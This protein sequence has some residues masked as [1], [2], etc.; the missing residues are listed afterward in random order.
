MKKKKKKSN[1][2]AQRSELTR[3]ILNI[4]LLAVVAGLLVLSIVLVRIKLLQNTHQLGMALAQSYAVEET[5]TRNTL[6][7]TALIA[8]QYIDEISSGGGTPEQIQHWMQSYFNKLTAIV[9]TALA[10][11][12]VVI[13]GQLI[14]ATPWEGDA[15]YDYGATQWYQLALQEHGMPVFSDVYTDAVTGQLV[16][17]LSMELA[18]PGDVLAMDIYIQNNERHNTLQTLPEG[19]SY[20]LCDDNGALLYAVSSWSTDGQSLQNVA[21]YLVRCIQ[22]GSLE[23]YDAFFRDPSNELRGAYY[24]V[25]DNG[26][27]VIVTIPIQSVLMG[28]ENIALYVMAGVALLLFTLLAALTV[29]DA[30]RWRRIKRADDTAHMLGDSF[31]AIFRINFRRGSYE[32]IKCAPD[33]VERLPPREDYPALLQLLCEHVKP[34]TRQT[35]AESFSLE[36]IRSRV[37]AKLADYGGDFQRQF[38]EVYHWVNVR[39]L[40]A[41][42]LVPDEVILCF[43]DVDAEKN[44]QLQHMQ[45]LQDALDIARHS[46]QAQS[47]FF[48]NMSHDMRTPLNAILGYCPL[49]RKSIADGNRDKAADELGKIEFAGRQ[50]LTLINDI[51]EFSRLEAGKVS[52][53][54]KEFDLAQLV[55]SIAD[56]F[57]VHAQEADKTLEVTLDLRDS[58]VVGDAN[59]L[60]QILNNLLS[61][62]FKYSDAGASVHLTVT[63]LDFQ[64]HSQY[65]FVIEDTGIG[66]SQDFLSH[67]FEPYSRE[68]SFTAHSTVGTGLGMTIVQGLVRQM[69]GDIQVES[70]LGQG[71]RFTITL[72]LQRSDQKAPPAPVI[73]PDEPFSWQGVRVLVAEDNAM[74]RELLTELLQ[75]SGAQVLQAINGADA[76]HTFLHEPPG[77]IDV[78]LMDMRMPVMDGCQA[79]RILRELLRDDARQVP[80]VAV[81]ANA[82]AEDMERTVQ[83]GMNDHV[84]KPID[85]AQLTQVVQRLLAGRSAPSG[86]KGNG[87]DE[88]S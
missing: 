87:S 84:A 74:N 10:D 30:M 11:P 86:G 38:G 37:D 18:Q 23:S 77:S 63:Q 71:T 54:R 31:Y 3:T 35:F 45:V 4:L 8:G 57:R 13:D 6:Q 12:Y 41:P 36:S 79:T 83:A 85:F 55:Q 28:D 47:Q 44:Q 50:L 5:L 39:T 68:T 40:Y 78:I 65:R 20:Y 16:I 42:T 80:I 43:R 58:L 21:S 73:A 34:E 7:D 22:D 88:R 82:F 52:M 69:S 27:M 56:L 49:V 14:G 62:A 72:P 76:V 67:L 51:L 59:L 19:Y 25:M 81:T 66:M 2:L 48:S 17:T 33:L 26:W 15:D 53:D 75:M 24:A 9:G 46:T 1:L 70:T 32:A 64:Q 60:T 29:R 61:N